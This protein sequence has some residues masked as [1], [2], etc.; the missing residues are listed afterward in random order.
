MQLSDRGRGGDS[1]KGGNGPILP[2]SLGP[3]TCSETCY[4]GDQE[5][6][7]HVELVASLLGH[8]KTQG[9]GGGVWAVVVNEQRQC[10]LE[11]VMSGRLLEA[12]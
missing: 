1:L 3:Q 10:S 2:G 8:R 9:G 7:G 6:A 12:N 11:V 4:Q 5:G